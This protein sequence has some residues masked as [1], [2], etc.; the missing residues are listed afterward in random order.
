MASNFLRD[1]DRACSLDDDEEGLHSYS[2]PFFIVLLKVVGRRNEKVEK[3][4]KLL[5]FFI[6]LNRL[7]EEMKK[8]ADFIFFPFY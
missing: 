4:K 1:G 5:N 6:E 2:Q 8:L 7:P 3:T